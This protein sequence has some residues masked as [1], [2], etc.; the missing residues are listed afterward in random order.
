MSG[1]VTDPRDEPLEGVAVL[2]RRASDSA[3][4]AGTA[5]DSC[6]RFAFPALPLRRYRL[7]FSMVGYKRR[8]VEVLPRGERPFRRERSLDP[9]TL[10]ED[11]CPLASVV[12]TGKR[13][14]MKMDPGKTT[15]EMET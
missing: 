10:E 15:F 4:V 2:L 13:A 9:V 11:A 7:E 5:T 8:Q 12:V 14:F 3:Y 1:S 6:G